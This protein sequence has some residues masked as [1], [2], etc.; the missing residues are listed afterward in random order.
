MHVDWTTRLDLNTSFMEIMVA[1]QGTELVT[2]V[3]TGTTP[4]HRYLDF[5]SQAHGRVYIVNFAPLWTSWAE[6]VLCTCARLAE[7]WIFFCSA[8]HFEFDDTIF[9]LD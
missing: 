1:S 5:T 3:P 9:I 2:N 7:M 6:R 4:V 8:A